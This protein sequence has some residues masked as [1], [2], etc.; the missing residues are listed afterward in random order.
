M[1]VN[2]FTLGAVTV[3][4]R[5]VAVGGAFLLV[6]TVWLTADI[7]DRAPSGPLWPVAAGAVVLI[8][9]WRDAQGTRSV[10][11]AR[12][13]AVAGVVAAVL[14]WLVAA[15]PAAGPFWPA[16]VTGLLLVALGLAAPAGPV[17]PASR[18]AAAGGAALALALPVAAVAVILPVQ[19][20]DDIAVSASAALTP[21]S[22]GGSLA[23]R[24]AA[25][26]RDF[27]GLVAGAAVPVFTHE[28][29]LTGLDPATGQPRWRAEFRHTSEL[30]APVA[31]G[32]EVVVRWARDGSRST[33]RPRPHTA[34]LDART[35]RLLLDV[36]DDEGQQAAATL[37]G[38]LVRGLCPSG[39]TAALEALD[40]RTGR[41][42][43]RVPT[44]A[45]CRGLLRYGPGLLGV[46]DGGLQRVDATGAV[47][48]TWPATGG[49]RLLPGAVA[50][51]AVLVFRDAGVTVLDLDSG[52]ERWRDEHH[53][54]YEFAGLSG[55]TVVWGS[56]TRPFMLEAHA[57]ADGSATWTRETAFDPE[58]SGELTLLRSVFA[59]AGAVTVLH[60]PAGTRPREGRAAARFALRDGAPLPVDTLA[61]AADGAPDLGEPPKFAGGLLLVAARRPAR[62]TIAIG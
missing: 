43:W 34:V 4:G 1:L 39:G 18:R 16:V 44:A 10:R 48:W 40:L 41:R 58:Q 17:A 31:S 29:T 46:V 27:E 32:D 23:V 36:A 7:G 19:R 11:L 20:G 45:G 3:L 53:G 38:L 52:A 30:R 59:Y 49:F 61:P 12:A 55:G 21:W 25:P 35:G 26:D 28:R 22:P 15:D 37:P 47:R 50:D 42:A 54:A 24:W 8:V 60:D 57:L 9:V 2:A 5:S 6:A 14:G 56:R 13:V 51:G 62:G 33:G